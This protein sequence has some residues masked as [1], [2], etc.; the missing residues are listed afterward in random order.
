MAATKSLM[1]YKE[2]KSSDDE[3][4]KGS[5]RTGGGEEVPPKVQKISITRM[6]EKS[7]PVVLPGMVR[8]RCPIL[9]KIKASASSRSLCKAEVHLMLWSAFD[10]G[11]S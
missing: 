9:R 4:L 2:I 8:V 1:D 11:M 3:G 6:G 7:C 5:H 10:K